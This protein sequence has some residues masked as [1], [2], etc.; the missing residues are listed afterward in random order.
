[1]LN[2]DINWNEDI[3]EYPHC[4]VWEYNI[5]PGSVVCY[6][7]DP[8]VVRYI[9]H[10]LHV[11]WFGVYYKPKQSGWFSKQFVLN[12]KQLGKVLNLRITE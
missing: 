3:K 10:T 9:E 6:S 1:M 2:T 11:P 7:K 4:S 12:Q 8:E 5:F